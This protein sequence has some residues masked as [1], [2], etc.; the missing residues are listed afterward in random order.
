MVYGSEKEDWLVPLVETF[1]A[2]KNETADGAVIVIEATPMGSIESGDQIVAENIQP[3]VWSPA[4]SAYV[5]VT[6]ANWRQTH[7][8]DLVIGTPSDLVL[9]PVVIAMWRP[10]AEALGWPDTPIGWSDIA[11][12]ATSEE[13]WAAYGYPEWGSFKLGHT[14][15]NFSNSGIISVIAEAYAG[16][17]KQRG[18]TMDDL[19]RPEV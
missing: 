10:M 5:P 17:G 3:V 4:S 1:N 13:G 7:A 6:N 12:L 19:Q 9:S 8:E 14:H 15:P 16:A 2:E 11:E 18:L